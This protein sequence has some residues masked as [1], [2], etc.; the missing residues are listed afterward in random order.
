MAVLHVS[1]LAHLTF[2][3]QVGFDFKFLNLGLC[4]CLTQ[5]KFF[6]IQFAIWLHTDRTIQAGAC[7]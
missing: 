6:P 4:L 2:G 7:G 3:W 5:F 1:G